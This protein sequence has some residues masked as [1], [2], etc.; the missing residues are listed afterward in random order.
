M[1][2]EMMKGG[3]SGDGPVRF[4]VLVITAD[5]VA[6]DFL[7]GRLRQAGYGVVGAHDTAAV[8]RLLGDGTFDVMILDDDMHDE[9]VR[10]VV[11]AVAAGRSR[12][13]LP[14]I[15]LTMDG[16]A[17]TA[18]SRLAGIA[19]ERLAK[20]V[21]IEM[22]MASLETHLTRHPG[23]AGAA[24]ARDDLEQAIAR[25]TANLRGMVD[26]LEQAREVL[27]DALDA[28]E[29]GFVLWDRADRLVVCNESFRR[30][31]GANASHVAPGA[32]FEDLM[33]LQI[34]AGSLR[35]AVDGSREW[36]TERV[37][38]H[39]VPKDPFEEEYADGSWVRV[40]E[41]RTAS[42]YTVG[43]YTD[44]S[45][46]KRREIALKMFAENNRRLAAAVNA[47]SSAIL[48][49]DPNR[50][51]NPTVFANPAFTEM[52]GWPVEEALGR[53]RS[54]LLGPD[55]D[56]DAARRFEYN[57]RAGRPTSTELRL[58]TRSGKTFRAWVGASP[59]RNR[60]GRITNWV[61][62][63]TGMTGQATTGDEP[64]VSRNTETVGRLAVKS[65]VPS[66]IP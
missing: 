56:A 23:A 47:T 52:T 33:Q 38:R 16:A 12:G 31:F 29:E 49:T 1:N 45:E 59:I 26:K 54:F 39:R 62:V 57:M 17:P 8:R 25:R 64:T 20:P 53:D 2:R 24:R 46:A 30:L 60:E 19:D 61:I 9:C 36:L 13:G 66:T 41:T 6:R 35:C 51:G 7:C 32:G 63:Q 28:I 40:A 65:P 5:E 11:A 48:I 10:E 43:L 44:V 21:D 22:L 4:Q 18:W 50:P 15:L 34:D 27:A 42:G 37:A 3:R 55:A 14:A 58:K